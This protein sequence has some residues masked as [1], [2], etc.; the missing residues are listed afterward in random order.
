MGSARIKSV[1]Q[2]LALTLTEHVKSKMTDFMRRKPRD[3][4]KLEHELYGDMLNENSKPK[5]MLLTE[6]EST[7]DDRVLKSY[8]FRSAWPTTVGAIELSYDS[9]D[10]IEE[11]DVTWRYQHFEASSV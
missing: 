10:A 5:M 9:T 1:R 3:R 11:F 4:T 8:I 7:R 6:L 2:R